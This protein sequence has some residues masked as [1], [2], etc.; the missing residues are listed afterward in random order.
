M[1]ENLA[2]GKNTINGKVG[3]TNQ[4]TNTLDATLQ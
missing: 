4:T 2:Q 1:R 3:P